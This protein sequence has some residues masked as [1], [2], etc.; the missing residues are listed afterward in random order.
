MVLDGAVKL[1]GTD[2]MVVLTEHATYSETD[3]VVLARPGRWRS[4][5]GGCMRRVSA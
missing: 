1:E 5:A 4:R 2:G 3:A